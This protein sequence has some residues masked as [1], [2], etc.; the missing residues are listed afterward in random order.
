MSEQG[1][2]GNRIELR[3]TCEVASMKSGVVGWKKPHHRQALI[4]AFELCR[5]WK[6]TT[7]PRHARYGS[8]TAFGVGFVSYYGRAWQI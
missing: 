5:G 2:Q 4:Y 1:K 3:R 7:G 8:K 6:E